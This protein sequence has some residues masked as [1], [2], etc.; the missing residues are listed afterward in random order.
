MNGLKCLTAAAIDNASISQ[1]SH[2][3]WCFLNLALKNQANNNLLLRETYN[4]APSPR[5]ETEPSVTIHNW[6]SGRGKV[7]VLHSESDCLALQN[8]SDN[9]SV[10]T[11]RS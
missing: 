11:T 6:S 4:V 7:I 3:T 5:F 2:V 8:R 9:S 10:H 1:G